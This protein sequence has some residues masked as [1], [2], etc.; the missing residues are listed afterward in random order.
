MVAAFKVPMLKPGEYE[1]WRMR[2]EQYIQM[3]HY[4]LWEVIEN[5]AT[6]P[7]TNVVEGVTTEMP[8]ATAEENAQRRLE[9]KVRST[10]K[11]GIPNKHQLKF[12]SI[13][14][15]KKLQKLVSQLEILEEKL[16]QEDA[17]QKLLRSLS[18]EWNTH[19]VVWRN[20]VDLD[21]MSMDDL[22]NN[23]KAY[24]GPNYALM[25]FSSSNS[26]L[27]VSNDSTCL[28]SC[29]ETLK[30]QNNQL[31]KDLKKSK[32]MVIGYKTSLK[33]MEERLE[34][35]KTNKFIYIEDI[36]VLKLEI[37]MKEIA[38]RELRK[39]LEIA[40]NEKDGI[41]VN[42]DKFEHASKS[43]KKLIECQMVDNCK[44]GL[45]YENYNAVPP[46]YT[47]NFMPP[48]PDLSLTSLDEFVN[49]RVVE[50]CKA[51]SSKEEPKLKNRE[52]NQF[53]EMKGILRQFS[54]ARTP[55]K[56][57]VAER[58]NR[59]LL[60]AARTMLAASKLPTTFWTE[61]VNI[62]CYVQNRVLVVKPHNK[63]LYEL[64]HGRTPPLSFLRPF[65]CPIII[66]NTIDHLGK[67]DGMADEG[68]FVG[69][70]L[71]SKAFRVF[72][73]KT[74]IVEENLHIR[75]SEST[76]NVVGSGLD[77]IFDIDALT[78]TMNYEPIVVGT[79]SNGFAG[80]KASDNAG[81]ARK[82]TELSKI[83]F[84]YHYGLLIHHFPKI[85]RVLIMMDPN[86]Q[87]MMERSSTA[88]AAGTNKDNK[89]PFD[90]N[91][92]ALEDVS[93]FNFST[94]DEDDVVVADIN[95][96][97]ITIQIPINP[98][99]SHLHVVKRI[100][101]YLKGQP[102]LGLWYP[103]YSPFDLVAYTDSDYARTS[104]D[105]KST[106]RDGKK[107]V[108]TESSVRR[109]LQLADKKGIDCLPNSTILEQLA[110]MDEAI[111]KELGDRLVRATTTTSSLEAEQDSGNITKTQSKATPNEPS[112][113]GIDLGGG[114]RGNIIQS[115]EDSI[116]LDELMALCT[117]LQN[118][119]RRIDAND[120]DDEITLVNDADNEM[121]DVDDLGA[122]EVFVAEQEVVS[123]AAT[124]ETITTKEI[125]LAQAL[126]A[127][128]TSKPKVKGI[129]FNEPSESTTTLPKQQSQDKEK[130]RKHFVAKRAK[131]KRRK[132]QTQAQQK[133]IMC[134]YLKNM[135]GYKLKDLKLKE[136]DKIQKMFDKAFKRQKVEDDKETTELKLLMENIL[137]EEE[138]PIDAIPLAVKS[139]RIVD[140]KIHKEG[141]KS[142]YQIVRA[143]GKS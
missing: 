26:G 75:F 27:E 118:K 54:V 83:T 35:C 12:N 97:D 40:Q 55:Q 69:Y 7:K 113:Q 52:M 123:T 136:F 141:K 109:D 138:A 3:I 28:K 9:V 5:G 47:R 10:L 51:K 23:L 49:K 22:Y 30:S 45:G 72:N 81:Q 107:I 117:N 78:R 92:P 102:K 93:I 106:T 84:C 105:R 111:H 67:F 133:K 2:I 104:L 50:N 135:E 76:P 74:R 127:L 85:Q 42:V 29:L 101:R 4:A 115:D 24:E 94:D 121:F 14:D 99:V 18:P 39:K 131:E 125:T 59:T 122:E 58:R 17:N 82:E 31:L 128:K 62:A 70:F 57:R 120:A 139:L 91:M 6:L 66:F 34:F 130:R 41:Q 13:K 95:N 129:V 126:K 96:L 44:K 33:S 37:Q 8:I 98:K 100:F 80:T 16:S 143:D 1:I 132:P 68:F 119:G 43:L 86:L 48:T 108:I 142:Y 88:N 112:S 89:L 15:A 116:K 63:T 21:T 90:L 73:S 71:N 87:V 77:W 20:K 19:V 46:P 114:P 38:I 53:C 64:F 137:D 65:G 61:A 134:T 11:M 56:N 32:L 124:T 60:E 79:Q 36:K 103:K 25:A 140:W 110:L